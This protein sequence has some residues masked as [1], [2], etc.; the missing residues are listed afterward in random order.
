MKT[1]KV[2]VFRSEYKEA[3]VV[4]KAESK[5]DAIAQAKQMDL[6]YYVVDADE[7]YEAVELL[8]EEANL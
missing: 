6:D 3:D 5:K 4:I 8:E 7:N 1:Y 2:L